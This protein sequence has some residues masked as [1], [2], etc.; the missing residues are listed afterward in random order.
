MTDDQAIAAIDAAHKRLRDSLGTDWQDQALA[1]L[2]RLV[3]DIHWQR[4][5]AR[6]NA[7]YSN[8]GVSR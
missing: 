1:D 3:N 2:R 6:W 4:E 7:F 5:A 8:F